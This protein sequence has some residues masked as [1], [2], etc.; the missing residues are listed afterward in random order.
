MACACRLRD[1]LFRYPG[2]DYEL[3]IPELRVDAGDH[4]AV[5]AGDAGA[6]MD[7]SVHRDEE[8]P[9]EAGENTI[10]KLVDAPGASV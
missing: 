3:R 4:V 6:R 7:G 1:V 10:L 9:V 2:G 5:I 8:G